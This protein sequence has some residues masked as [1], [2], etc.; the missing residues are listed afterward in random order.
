VDAILIGPLRGGNPG[1]AFKK[2]TILSTSQVLAVGAVGA[3]PGAPAQPPAV[4]ASV[5]TK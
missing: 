3:D 1:G 5:E 2:L 4:P